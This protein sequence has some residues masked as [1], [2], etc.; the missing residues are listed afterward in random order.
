M[1]YKKYNYILIFILMLI[2]G[3]NNVHAQAPFN[4][5]A[6]EKTCY[7]MSDDASFKARIVI[8]HSLQMNF[9]GY[10]N[11]GSSLIEYESNDTYT[12]VW[13]DKLGDNNYP[14]DEEYI[15]NWAGMFG[16]PSY[17]IWDR[18]YIHDA[19]VVF[20]TYY[21][22][23]GANNN[24]PCPGYIVFEYADGHYRAWAT[25]N[26]SE[27][28]KAQNNINAGGYLGYYG[29]P[30][31]SDKYFQEWVDAGLIKYNKDEAVTCTTYEAIF[32]SK[33]DPESIRYMVDEVLI[34]VRIIVPILIIVL[35]MVDFGKAVLANKED[36]MKKA[37]L[38]FAKRVFIGVAVFFVPVL[39]DLVMDLADILWLSPE[40]GAILH[41][42]PNCPL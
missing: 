8:Y 2:I 3:V 27:A 13:I 23:S 16:N 42:L 11:F 25:E 7:Y 34:Y 33:D 18:M 39:V 28:Q 41:G 21:D 35:G 9:W 14:Y 20:S 15:I 5:N 31:T 22:I 10:T 38:D 1:K 32:G 30:A 19:S 26:L 24:P 6:S 29:A 17:H 4:Y 36:T 40:E 12:D 37:Q